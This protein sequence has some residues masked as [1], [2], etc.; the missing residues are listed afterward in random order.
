MLNPDFRDMLSEL[1]AAGAD[2]IVVGAYALAAHGLPR[3][4]GDIDIWVRAEPE[5][6]RRVRAALAQFGAPLAD[7]S[8]SDLGSHD[9]V[10][11][12]GIAPRRIDLMTSVDGLDFEGA[13]QRRVVTTV[14]GVQLSVLSREDLIVNKRATGRAKDLADV[15]WLEDEGD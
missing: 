14:D 10:F 12:I 6:A 3:A 2:F 7:L 4:T 5:N 9:V 8:E 1:N 15:A 13:W 11:Q